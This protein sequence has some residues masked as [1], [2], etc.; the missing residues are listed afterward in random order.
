M[1]AWARRLE[2]AALLGYV[3]VALVFAWPLPLHL[4]DALLGLP[5]GDTGVYVWNLWVF[6]H[7]IVANH[8]LPFLTSE[9]LALNAPVPLALHNYTTVANILAFPLLPILGIVRTY[10]L[11]VIAAGVVTAFVMFLYARARTGDAAASWIGGL[12]FGFSPFMTVRSTEHFSLLLAAPIPLFAWLLYRIWSKPTLGLSCAAGAT[13][14]L[15]FLCDAYYAVYCL[16]MAAF[17]AIYSVFSV[18]RQSPAV[19]R[20]WWP[21][22]L[23]LSIVC[24]AGFIV[25]VVLRGGG[26]M[27]FFGIRM[28]VTH[29]YNPMLILTLLVVLRAWLTLRPRI[30]PHDPLVPLL[31]AAVPAAVVCLVILAPVL[32]AAG[33]PFRQ[34]QWISPD[35]FWRNSPPGVDLLAFLAP[36]P[37]HSWFR[38]IATDWLTSMTN[39]Y[40]EN[41]ASVP[42]VA[43][44]TIGLA[45]L[46]TRFRPPVGWIAFTLCFAWLALGPFVR[47]AGV[48]TYVPTPW[49]LL[50]YAPVLGAARMPTRMTVLVMLGVSML[51]AM[52]LTHARSRVRRPGLLTVG[53]GA[54]LMFELLP[55]PRPLYSAEV[56]LVYRIVG[57]DPRPVRLLTLPFGLRDGVS[58]R[59]N[60]NAV[61]QYY[62]TVHQKRLVGGYI[63]RL[64]RNSVAR[65]R[66]Y[67]VMRVL[68][69]LS[70]GTPVE[71]ALFEAAYANADPTLQRLEIGYVVIN[72]RRAPR[73]LAAFAKS[74][75]QLSPVTRDGD[76]E[77][78]RTSL[79]PPR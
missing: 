51:L 23:N 36:N 22:L 25:G 33:S 48:F 41:V 78:Y 54:L 15:A 13:V 24:V 40:A 69:R 12:L 45:V 61:S 37:E 17:T 6:R 57:E 42:W 73:E 18:E 14:A 62:Q 60:F 50:R 70:E 76:F 3:F 2:A 19:R 65:Y 79:A 43:L 4:G 8:R 35:I 58:S 38:W 77:L 29:L 47:V 28:S 52:A 9:I 10:N 64:P 53:I 34:R 31:K 71:P 1:P 63:S 67:P 55:V 56:P 46:F 66:R 68:M 74:A 16:M 75:F 26:R 49:A 72:T 30:V 20:V 27:D 21:A 11:L 32:Y 39:A 7:E 59:G 44:I 5:T